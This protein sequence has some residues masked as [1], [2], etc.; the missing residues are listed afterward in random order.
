MSLTRERALTISSFSLSVRSRLESWAEA[1]VPWM[2]ALRS[3]SSPSIR[4]IM[5]S[6]WSSGMVMSLSGSGVGQ[7]ER[8]ADDGVSHE[9]VEDGC[10]RRIQFRL[11]LQ[12]LVAD[13][14][15]LRPF[16][17]GVL[18]HCQV[19]KDGPLDRSD[20]VPS[21]MEHVGRLRAIA[22]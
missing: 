1:M 11:E 15:H 21:V 4:A 7:T 5:A 10:R 16:V 9:P 8:P 17:C 13:L 20:P 19:V 12:A 22:D 18:H 14:Q 3:A 2:K 6:D